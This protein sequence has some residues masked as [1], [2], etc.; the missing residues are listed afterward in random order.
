[1]NMKRTLIVMATWLS[2]A[3][4]CL[5]DAE[6]DWSESATEWSPQSYWEEA[7]I[8]QKY[9]FTAN[10]ED[11]VVGR[12]S[13][14]VDMQVAGRRPS[15]LIEMRVVPP[16]PLDLSKTEAIEVHLKS[17]RGVMLTPRDVF[18]CNP[19]FTKLAIVKWPRNSTCRPAR[20]G[21]A[22]C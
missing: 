19:G 14:Q 21:S 1:M 7:D 10:D 9:T 20:L 22:L 3:T 11:T 6:D 2:I 16:E 13:V 8:L 18:L 15:N 12:S 17:V 4:V 5:A